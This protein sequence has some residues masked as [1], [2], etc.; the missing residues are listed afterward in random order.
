MSD[1]ISELAINAQDNRLHFEQLVEA[2]IIKDFDILMQSTNLVDET[3]R[4]EKHKMTVCLNNLALLINSHPNVLNTKNAF[5][6]KKISNSSPSLLFK[7]LA[8][9]F[10]DMK[11]VNHEKNPD[12]Y[13]NES[14]C[15]RSR[16][17]SEAS[18]RT[19]EEW[20]NAILLNFKI[21]V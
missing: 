4:T 13:F 15:I 8:L 9:K 18:W 12:G 3:I 11:Y 2:K 7:R 14:I 17:K 21:D 20:Y 5:Y 10:C 6:G 19:F 1:E 16:D